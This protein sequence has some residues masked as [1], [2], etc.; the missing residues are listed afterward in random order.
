MAKP[1]ENTDYARHTI[2]LLRCM[3]HRA[4]LAHHQIDNIIS[5][6]LDLPGVADI[7]QIPPISI[8]GISVHMAFLGHS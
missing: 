7:Q 8:P 1:S 4:I 3:F 2:S 5:W 6:P